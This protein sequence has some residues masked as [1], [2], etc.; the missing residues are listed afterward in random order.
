M[1][2]MGVKEEITLEENRPSTLIEAYR[3]LGMSGK[4]V[5]WT[6]I[7]LVTIV[8]IANLGRPDQGGEIKD[9]RA[10]NKDLHSQVE[11]LQSQKQDLQ[12]KVADLE[13]E[14]ADLKARVEDLKAESNAP[15]AGISSHKKEEKP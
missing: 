13:A 11:D 4:V 7:V 10:E 6:F 8:I 9:L 2:M 3:S 1:G 5:V 12:E 15:A 14:N